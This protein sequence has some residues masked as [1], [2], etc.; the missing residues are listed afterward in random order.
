MK[1]QSDRPELITHGA[2]AEARDR[3]RLDRLAESLVTPWQL[4]PL[5]PQ[6]GDPEP[7]SGPP[8]ATVVDTDFVVAWQLRPRSPSAS[9]QVARLCGVGPNGSATP[10]G[11]SGC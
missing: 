3:C 2:K 4:P 9:R 7:H 5:A 10:P 8:Q 6:A 11:K 1:D